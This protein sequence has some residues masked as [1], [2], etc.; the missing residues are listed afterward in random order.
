MSSPL[1][2][3]PQLL[4]YILINVPNDEHVTQHSN[5]TDIDDVRNPF[6]RKQFIFYVNYYT[7]IVFIMFYYYRSQMMLL[8]RQDV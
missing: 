8:Y 6:R 2:Q 5:S 4:D 3:P 7:I 1:H